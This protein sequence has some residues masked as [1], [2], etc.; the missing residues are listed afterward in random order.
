M[1]C[2]RLSSPS[3][4]TGGESSRFPVKFKGKDFFPPSRR[5]W[6]TTVEGFQR[7]AKANRLYAVGDSLVWKNYHD[8][9][10][11]RSITNL[12]TDTFRT[13]FGEKKVYVVQTLSKVIERCLLMTTEPGDL[14][15][16]PTCGSGTTAY[17]AETW[18]RR[19]ITCDTSRVAL[20][21]SRERLLTAT[22]PYYVLARPEEGVR[23][24]FQYQVIKRVTLKSLAQGEPPEIVNLIDRVEVDPKATRVSGPFTV[25]AIPALSVESALTDKIPE[26]ENYVSTLI[27]AIQAS[28]V[29]FPGGKTL[30]LLNVVPV[31]SAG[32]IHAEGVTSNGE[33]RRVAISFG[34]RYGPLG[35]KQAEVAIRTATVNGYSIL[36]L[37]G[38][39]IDTA[40][41]TFVQRTSTKLQVQF[42]NINPDMEIHDLL[43]QTQGS[44]LFSVF[45]EPDIKVLQAGK[46]R[47]VVKLQG[48]DIY[49]PTTGQISQSAADDLPA[50]FL[51]EDYDG[52]SFN[53]CQAFFP[54]G[55]TGK[56]PWDK[57]EHALRGLIDKEKIEQFRGTESLAFES[58][59]H[60]AIAVKVLDNRGNE[61]VRIRKLRN[62]ARG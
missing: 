49:D 19:W 14:V 10:P 60:N 52:Y 3:S 18:G 40:A 31:S 57:L 6:S 38:F 29:V 24:G 48:I 59:D 37:A 2:L 16:D 5:G 58:G 17:A 43:K 55:A 39:T 50:W 36:V 7:L 12:W 53:I 30:K 28:G 32:F 11:F 4:Q 62:G 27:R 34:P 44:Q 26:P 42:A 46:G 35:A 54:N 21:I 23:S 25:E 13:G 61:V 47:Y 15:F 22:Y 41:Q 45:G 1:S 51:D 33:S 20:L 56:D 9:F 8:D